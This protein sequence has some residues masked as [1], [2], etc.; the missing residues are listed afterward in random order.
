MMKGDLPPENSGS[1]T[2]VKCD[3][4]REANVLRLFREIESRMGHMDILINNAGTAVLG[5]LVDD[6]TTT[7]GWR[8]MLDVRMYCS[9]LGSKL[10]SIIS[11]TARKPESLYEMNPPPYLLF[12]DLTAT[13]S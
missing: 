1:V 5:G 8:T 6:E 10:F 11:E 2:A 12:Y 3:L 4:L 9:I 13:H 7:A